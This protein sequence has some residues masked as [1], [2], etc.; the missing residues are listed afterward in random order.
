M[1]DLVLFFNGPNRGN[2][3]DSYRERNRWIVG[4]LGISFHSARTIDGDVMNIAAFKTLDEAIA[5]LRRRAQ[6]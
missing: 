3:L 4:E 5:E 1:S 6:V 2:D